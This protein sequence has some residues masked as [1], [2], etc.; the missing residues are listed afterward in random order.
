[1]TNEKI[2]DYVSD[3]GSDILTYE[4]VIEESI[5][6]LKAVNQNQDYGVFLV[7]PQNYVCYEVHTCLLPT[8]W[9]MA[10]ECT[11]PLIEWVFRNTKCQRLVTNVPEYNYRA[12]SLAKRSGLTEYGFNEKSYLKNGKL[13]SQIMLGISKED[14]CQQ[15]Q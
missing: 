4:P 12:L 9:G 8:V 15:Q 2:W 7:H 5:Y 1:V 11:I 6:W 13:F 14:V 3:D 10:L